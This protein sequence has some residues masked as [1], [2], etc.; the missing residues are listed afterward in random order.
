MKKNLL[1]LSFIV[2]GI[3]SNG[4]TPSCPN[5]NFEQWNSTTWEN[6]QYYPDNSNASNFF[7]FNLPANVTKTTDA[8]HGNYAVQLTT[9]SSGPDTAAAYFLNTNP[10]NSP[11]NWTGGMAYNQQP[12]GI[13]GYYKY[14]V[15]TADSATI[16]VT[17]S[18][19][20]VNVG[21][22]MFL[23]GGIQNNY[24]LFNFVFNPALTV[25]PDSV[26][27]AAISCKISGGQGAPQGPP[28]STLIL[29]SV[30]FTGVG[31]QP[32]QMNGDFESWQNQT[33]ESPANWY[34]QSDMG[35]GFNKTTDSKAGNYAIELKTY[36]GSNQY[37]QPTARS[38]QVST[39]YW[40][41]NCGGGCNQLGGFPFANQV[42]TLAFYYK[43]TPSG[44]DSAQVFMSFKKNSANIWGSGMSLHASS[45]YQYK[46]MPFNIGQILIV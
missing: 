25:T 46:E 1:L 24:T 36:L 21:A 35:E 14:N 43:Y 45:V 26:I 7:R 3:I 2:I 16:I 39:G 32:A 9:I 28:G 13:R 18:K 10:Q 15:A 29:D 30:S 37:N 12:T 6:P 8:Y 42:D 11:N 44:N 41:N 27:F 17:F 34:T 23:L 5:G 33:F 40:P 4:Q 22:Y 31:S 20:G 19:A 38:G